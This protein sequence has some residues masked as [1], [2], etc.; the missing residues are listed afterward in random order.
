[1]QTILQIAVAQTQETDY[2]ESLFIK[3]TKHVQKVDI[4]TSAKL[5]FRNTR[6]A[7]EWQ[8]FILWRANGVF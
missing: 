8:I 3:K 7:L 5:I 4:F 2:R 1:M 6:E